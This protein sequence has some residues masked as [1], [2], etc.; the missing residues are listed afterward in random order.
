M[1]IEK[2]EIDGH[3]VFTHDGQSTVEDFGQEILAKKDDI[4]AVSD[5]TVYVGYHGDDKGEFHHD[6]DKDDDEQ[7][8]V[9][10]KIFGN[11]TLEWVRDPG[12]TDDEIK[13]A[14]KSGNVF[15]TWC[16]SDSKI[17]SVFGL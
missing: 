7:T 4:S 10:A 17:K 11:A 5:L 3:V 1:T 12:M 15:F 13:A 16:D 2:Y 14:V 8:E 6:F 9:I